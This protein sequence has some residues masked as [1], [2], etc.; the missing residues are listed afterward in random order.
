[1]ARSP[2][3]LPTP[4]RLRLLA[5][6][7]AMPTGESY[8]ILEELAEQTSW[9]QESLPELINLPLD[10]W[11]GEHTRLFISGLPRTA[12]PPFAS[13]YREG[14]M[15][16]STIEQL[17][18]LYQRCGLESRDMPLDYLGALLELA[19]H[20]LERPE[21]LDPELW[22]ALW[23]EHLATWAPRFARD[24]IE[25][26]HLTLYRRLGEELMRLFPPHG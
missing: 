21:P 22:T 7:L 17:I 11:Q 9:L 23:N 19:A 3:T 14:L 16:G 6:L 26:S 20:L 12:C 10:R 1:M 24:L 5:G 2:T 8:Q 13:A 25:A 4:D 18:T 15:G